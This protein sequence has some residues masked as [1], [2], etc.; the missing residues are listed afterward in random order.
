MR[1][2]DPH[3]LGI[4]RSRAFHAA[5]ADRLVAEP[6]LVDD[7]LAR[8]ARWSESAGRSS[9]LF[10]AWETALRGPRAALVEL[11]LREDERTDELR[12]C[13]PFAGALPARE[14]WTIWRGRSAPGA[15]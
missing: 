14:R 8:L 5:V 2:D 7:A 1:S 4:R 6:R 10:A 13:T 3:A 15:S 12:S 11:L 9:P